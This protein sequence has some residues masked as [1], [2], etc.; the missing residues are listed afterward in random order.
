MGLPPLSPVLPASLGADL[1]FFF[2]DRSDL[3]KLG[4]DGRATLKEDGPMRSISEAVQP[5]QALHTGLNS[6]QTPR[7]DAHPNTWGKA[8]A[9]G[10]YHVC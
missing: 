1:F 5:W 6:L 7:Q 3:P 4:L 9:Q 10:D 8:P 2:F